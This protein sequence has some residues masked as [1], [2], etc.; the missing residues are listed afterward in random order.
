METINTDTNNKSV[1]IKLKSVDR[2]KYYESN[3]AEI[4]Y[5]DGGV[6]LADVGLTTNLVINEKE[7]SISVLLD[8]VYKLKEEP[9]VVLFSISSKHS[10]EIQNLLNVI[11]KDDKQQCRIPDQLL[12]MLVSIAYSGTRGMLAVLITSPIYKDLILPI[13]DPKKLINSKM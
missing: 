7:E 12:N 5:K 6:D 4:G 3:P 10:Y 11:T 2:M 9:E 8:V 1:N 13:I